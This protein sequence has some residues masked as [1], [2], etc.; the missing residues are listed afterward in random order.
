MPYRRRGASLPA[1]ELHNRLAGA[2]V[3]V[4]GTHDEPRQ[5]LRA[6]G[7]G[8]ASAF[9]GVVD[10]F[11][12]RAVD[13]LDFDGGSIVGIYIRQAFEFDRRPG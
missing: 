9:D 13:A 8:V 7:P 12:A 11:A 1:E 6:A 10:D 4:N 3:A 2:E 5:V